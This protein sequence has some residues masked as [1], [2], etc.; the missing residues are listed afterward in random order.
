MLKELKNVRQNAGE[1]HR[2]I[3]QDEFFDL[4]IWTNSLNEFS[5]FQLCYQKS[6]SEKVLSRFNSSGFLHSGIDQGEDSSNANRSPLL[7]ADGIFPF[8]EIASLFEKK[9][10]NIDKNIFIF[11]KQKIEEY[12]KYIK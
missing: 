7:V 2:R 6:K 3:F 10:K 5:G 11:V 4:Y 12:S 8:L 1:D 9:S